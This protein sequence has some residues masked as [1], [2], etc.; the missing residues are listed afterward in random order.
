MSMS[1]IAMH[2]IVVHLVLILC[3]VHPALCPLRTALSSWYVAMNMLQPAI[4]FVPDWQ[5]RR[6]D[7]R[8]IS[9]ARASVLGWEEANAYIL[10]PTMDER[11]Q[12]KQRALDRNIE[13]DGT[14]NVHRCHAY[15]T[16]LGM[17]ALAILRVLDRGMQI[18]RHPCPI[19][20]GATYGSFLGVAMG[21]ISA[22]LC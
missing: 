18:Q 14:R 1:I 15:G 2:A 20:I 8:G 17:A 7:H 22:A 21:A 6:A 16:I 12:K 11:T 5:R 13:S 19:V 3:G 4:L 10:G 9:F